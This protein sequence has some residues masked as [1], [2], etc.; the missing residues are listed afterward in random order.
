MLKRTHKH[1]WHTTAVFGQSGC[2]IACRCGALVRVLLLGGKVRPE[3]LRDG[4]HMFEVLDGLTVVELA[5]EV[6]GL[7]GRLGQGGHKFRTSVTFRYSCEV[8]GGS[9][10]VGQGDCETC[11]G[12]GSL[13]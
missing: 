7:P 8:C 3:V 1:D 12:S 10:I 2:V 9:G 6:I 4:G 11:E 13:A 5:A